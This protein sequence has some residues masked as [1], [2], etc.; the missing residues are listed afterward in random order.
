MERTPWGTLRSNCGPGQAACATTLVDRPG[1][2]A[3]GR[4]QVLAIVSQRRLWSGRWSGRPRARRA[5]S[6]GLAGP[7]APQHWWT[8]PAAVA[9]NRGQALA[10][11]SQCR[12]CPGRWGGR[13]RARR[14]RSAGLARQLAPQHWWTAPA[15]V[16]SNRGQALAIVSQCRLCPGRWGGRPRARRARSAGL[17]RQLA[18]QHWWTDRAPLRPDAARSWPSS[19]SAGCVLADGANALGHVA[20]EL[21][22]WPGSLRH[23]AGG[24]TG[25][26]C[27]RARP[28]PGHRLSAPALVWPMERTASG[29]SR[30]KRGPGR[31]AC[32]AALVDRAG[33][34]R[35]QPRPGPGHRLSVPA[36]S[37]P[38]GRTASG[39]SRSKCGPGQA[40]CAA[41]LVDRAGSRRVQPRPGPGHRL[42][43]PALSGPMGRTASGTSRSKCGPGQAA[44]AAALVDRPGTVASGRGQVL[45]I[46]SQ[47]RLCPGRW[48][49]RPGARRARTAGLARQLAPQRWWT[50]RAPLRPGAARSWPSSLSAGSGLADGADGLGHVA[51]EA[52]AWPG[53]LRRSTGGPRRQPSRPTAAR[54]WP[55]S[56]SAGSGLADGADGLGHVALEPRAWP[57]SLRRSTGGPRRQPSRPTAARP[58]PSSLSA[59]SGLAD[60]ADGLGHVALEVRRRLPRGG[61]ARSAGLARQL[62]PQRW[63]TDRAPLRPDAARSWPSSLSAG[64]V[65]A[66]GAN[67]LGH[68]ALELRAWPGSLRH[69][70]G[71]P[72][73]HRCVRTRPGPGH[74]L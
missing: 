16:A 23:N 51:L 53:R 34:R 29:T 63:R 11:V 64:C 72:T 40:A 9:S 70:A 59:G 31:A 6:A 14:A 37:G 5:R 50:D 20:L 69:N 22:A 48:S 44:C 35:V 68:V 17:A 61:H 15:A 3:S 19:L 52:R 21:R 33:S 32:A 60:G 41:A 67:A 7:L 71:G 54:P 4:G 55:S 2:V 57:G 12:L 62:A 13:P 25:H 45:A 73:G 8:A 1:T 58:W 56:L 18:P 46:V 10:I 26:R 27:V 24:P 74:R 39:T 30:S 38:M 42:S 43:V 65:L 66:D 36:L 28:G 47:R 49:E